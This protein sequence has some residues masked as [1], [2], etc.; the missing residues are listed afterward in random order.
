MTEEERILHAVWFD[1]MMVNNLRTFVERC[2]ETDDPIACA[3]AFLDDYVMRIE[4]QKGEEIEEFGD[5]YGF[6]YTMEQ[7]EEIDHVVRQIR[8]TVIT[9]IKAYQNGRMEK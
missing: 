1:F 8:A 6:D 9:T 2:M 3:N 7:T 4:R 5:I